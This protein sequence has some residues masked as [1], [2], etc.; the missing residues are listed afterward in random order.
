[1]LVSHMEARVLQLLNQCRTT[2]EAVHCNKRSHTMQLRP[3][4]A[5]L[6]YK[7]ANIYIIYNANMYIHMEIWKIQLDM[8]LE[9]KREVKFRD[10]FW[11]LLH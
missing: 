9:F 4:S 3:D 1:M 8:S 2:R 5:K 10:K 11:S 6:I 7:N